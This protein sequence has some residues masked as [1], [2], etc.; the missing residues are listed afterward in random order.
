MKHNT[1]IQWSSFLMIMIIIVMILIFIS[2]SWVK[3]SFK[4]GL[5]FQSHYLESN[6]ITTQQKLLENPPF[7]PFHKHKHQQK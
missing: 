4:L 3:A 6:N 7:F 5:C 1:H 2:A